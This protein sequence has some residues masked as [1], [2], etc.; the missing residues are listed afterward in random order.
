MRVSAKVSYDGRF[1][2]E[3]PAGGRQAGEAFVVGSG[4]RGPGR[5]YRSGPERAGGAAPYPG[6]GIRRDPAGYQHAGDGRI[7]DRAADPSA[8]EQRARA[9]YFSD[10]DGG[11]DA[12]G[13]ELFAGGGGLHSH[14]GG[15]AD[16]AVEGGGVR[17]SIQE[18]PAGAIAGGAPAATGDAASPADGC[19]AGD[20]LGGFGAENRA[21]DDRHGQGID[22]HEPGDD[23]DSAGKSSGACGELLFAVGQERGLAKQNPPIAGSQ[24][25][26]AGLQHE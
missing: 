15:A 22:R 19:L 1:E 20:Q 10:R 14:A 24:A 18:I 16:F 12:R 9:D 8:A 23:A 13:A 6:R 4:A 21:G 5:E 25:L 7:R 2:G 3:Y 11:R 26:H 17:G